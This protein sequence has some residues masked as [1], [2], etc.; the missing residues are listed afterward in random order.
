MRHGQRRHQHRLVV[1]VVVAVTDVRRVRVLQRVKVLHELD[2]RVARFG[3]GV[4]FCS[5]SISFFMFNL[6]ISQSHFFFI[7]SA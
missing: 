7:F 6:T 4:L 5:S 1:V 3:E 2:E